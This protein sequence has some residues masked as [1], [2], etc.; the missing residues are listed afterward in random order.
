[1]LSLEQRL[2]HKSTQIKDSY[3]YYQTQDQEKHTQ[4]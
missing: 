2:V 1:M 4:Q 3:Y